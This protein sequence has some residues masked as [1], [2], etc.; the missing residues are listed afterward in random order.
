MVTISDTVDKKLLYRLKI[1]ANKN[2]T[3]TFDDLPSSHT[4]SQSYAISSIKFG[5][6][7]SSKWLPEHPDV[8]STKEI[9]VKQHKV[10][11]RPVH[12]V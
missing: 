4:V 8:S 12:C 10:S 11:G 9:T 2:Q 3:V 7:S 6:K 5:K 1:A